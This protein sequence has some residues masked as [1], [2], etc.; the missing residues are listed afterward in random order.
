M[1]VGAKS[2]FMP[3]IEGLILIDC[4]DVEDQNIVTKESIQC[5][6]HDLLLDL[7]KFNIKYVVN[8]ITQTHMLTIEPSLVETYWNDCEVITTQDLSEFESCCKDLVNKNVSEWYVAG[9][10]WQMCV[11]EN[12]I[13]LENLS[14]ISKNLP[15]NFYATSKSFLKFSGQTVEH[16]DFVEDYLDWKFLNWFGYQLIGSS[17]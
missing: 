6:Y 8:A 2:S 13:G 11:H 5:F 17:K 16:E 15:A 14:K 7:K 1:I 12:S 3:K 10:S 4:W 9:Q